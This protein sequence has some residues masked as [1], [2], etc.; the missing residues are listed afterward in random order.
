[1]NIM[2]KE[3]EIEGE[4]YGLKLNKD[5]CEM[6]DPIGN[7]EVNFRDGAKLRKVKRYNI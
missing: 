5:K 7:S 1:M 6:L 4:K 2:L 3:I